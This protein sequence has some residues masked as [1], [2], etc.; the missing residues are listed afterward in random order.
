V[1]ASL[2]VITTILG[3]T[4]AYSPFHTKRL[5]KSV[6]QSILEHNKNV[7]AYHGYINGKNE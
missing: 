2:V 1:K 7:S 5:S 4:H 6:Q 3:N